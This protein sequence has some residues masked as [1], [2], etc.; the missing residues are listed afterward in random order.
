MHIEDTL[1]GLKSDCS[2]STDNYHAAA[3]SRA[4]E[5]EAIS[6]ATKVLKE[7]TGGAA[8]LTYGLN[9]VSSFIQLGA[10]LQTG[11]VMGVRSLT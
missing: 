11:A 3:K 6:E 5:L 7:S 1:A 8:A 10:Q 2:A 4:E 9:Q